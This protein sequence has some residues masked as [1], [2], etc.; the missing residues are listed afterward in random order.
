MI[1]TSWDIQVPPRG[2]PP[3]GMLRLE[4]MNLDIL[5]SD[6]PRLFLF[7]FEEGR[8]SLNKKTKQHFFQGVFFV[9]IHVYIYITPLAHVGFF[10]KRTPIWEWT[11]KISG[12]FPTDS[13]TVFLRIKNTHAETNMAP[14]KQ[15]DEFPFWASA[16]FQGGLAVSFTEGTLLLGAC[17]FIATSLSSHMID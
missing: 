6:L 13:G 10:P 15:E 12:K 9:G 2:I 7:F 17:A 16:Y 14:E 1:L 3:R 8:N 5:R 4:W 11:W